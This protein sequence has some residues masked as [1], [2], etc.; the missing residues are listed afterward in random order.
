MALALCDGVEFD[1]TNIPGLRDLTKRARMDKDGLTWEGG[2]GKVSRGSLQDYDGAVAIKVLRHY[3]QPDETCVEKL[4]RHFCRELAVWHGLKHP[5]IIELLGIS[6]NFGP[7]PAMVSPWI[8]KGNALT[9]LTRNPGANRM[10]IIRGIASALLYMHSHDPPVIHGD[11][12][13]ENVLITDSGDALLCDFG[14]AKVLRE[15]ERTSGFTTTAIHGTF[16]FMAPELHEDLIWTPATDTYAFGG[17]CLQLLTGRPP[18]HQ[19]KG[20]VILAI[21]R[22]KKPDRPEGFKHD[23][24][25]NLS[26]ECWEFEP[27][28]RPSMRDIIQGLHSIS[29]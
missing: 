21:C 25:W 3:H 5:N 22:G 13:G 2:H 7:I 9:Y 20:N 6:T 24:M 11:L 18:F 1:I 16:V 29:L 28:Q 23:A 27:R 8:S 26:L 14:V 4:K 12:K 19:Y 10:R 17:T 15:A